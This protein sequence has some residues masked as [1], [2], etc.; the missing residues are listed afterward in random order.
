MSQKQGRVGS[1]GM[2]LSCKM[3]I[4]NQVNLVRCITIKILI[5]NM[6]NGTLLT[7]IAQRTKEVEMLKTRPML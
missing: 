4:K 2:V 3:H 6:Y 5:I 1:P 7:R